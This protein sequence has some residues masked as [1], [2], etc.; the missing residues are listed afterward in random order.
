MVRT[1]W[2]LTLLLVA[3]A[4]AQDE[5]PVEPA[6][7]AVERVGPSVVN[8]S[9][10][11][12]VE[13]EL[14]AHAQRP[15]PPAKGRA[16]NLGSGVVV[17]PG[18]YV[19]TNAHVVARASRILVGVPGIEGRLEAELVAVR[20][21]EDLALLQLHAPRELTAIE[22]A[23]PASLR[24]G[25]TCL[26]FGNPYGLESSVSRGVISA[27]GR[28]LRHAGHEFPER[29]L[30]TD[31]AINPGNSGGP[32]VNLQGELIGIN[33]AIHDQGQGIGFAIP[34]GHL[35]GAL[36]ALSEPGLLPGAYS[37]LVLEDASE[38]PQVIEVAPESPAARAG[39]QVGDRVVATGARPVQAAYQVQ[40]ALARAKVDEPLRLALLSPEGAR[41]GATLTP[42][43]APERLA[44]RARTGLATQV[45]TPSAAWRLGLSR[46][47]GVQ[48]IGVLAG[49]PGAQIGVQT[50]DVITELG[51]A[52]G[53]RRPLATPADFARALAEVEPGA[54]VSI[55]VSRAGRRFRGRLKVQ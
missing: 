3:S 52:S 53:T 35:R 55:T 34:V 23:D 43:P 51:F 41:R 22:L 30:Q 26:A 28:R 40:L 17:D 20:Y 44:I 45:L 46:A 19:L 16:V 2:S 47:E 42:T 4:L 15:T 1:L 18:G 50:G 38:G 8:L 39:I 6:V 48:V 33:T 12:L 31:A 36:R 7:L 11:Q 24:V 37:G 9:T 13:R 49:G 5:P 10:E 32:L 14:P 25:Q 27:R 21:A 54:E 29:F